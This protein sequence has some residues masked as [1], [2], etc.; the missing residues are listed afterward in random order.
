VA[1]VF[2]SYVSEDRSIAEKIASGLEGA[3]FSVWWDRHIHG[4]VGFRKEIDRQ[5]GAAKV[6]VVLWSTTSLESE[7]VCDEAQQARDHNK[8]IQFAA[9]EATFVDALR[10]GQDVAVADVVKHVKEAIAQGR[11]R[12][13]DPDVLA[14]A[15]VGVVGHLTRIFIYERGEPAETVADEAVAFCLEGLSPS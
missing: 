11:I 14:H 12:D 6:V 10:R 3:G 5:L 2:V 1:D 4:G 13:A 9:T 15:M 8:L 7:W